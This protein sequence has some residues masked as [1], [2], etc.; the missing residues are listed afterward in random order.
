VCCPLTA[1]VVDQLITP[2]LCVP[3]DMSDHRSGRLVY[4]KKN[5]SGRSVYL[6][7]LLSDSTQKTDLA[8]QCT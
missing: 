6:K 8:Y 3:L 4:E 7:I 2:P 1:L 5:R